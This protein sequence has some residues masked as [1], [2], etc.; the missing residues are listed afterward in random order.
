MGLAMLGVGLFVGVL[1][2]VGV[3]CLLAISSPEE[4]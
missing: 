3:M 4:E 1:I 2:G